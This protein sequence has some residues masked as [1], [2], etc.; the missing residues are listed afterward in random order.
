MKWKS[1]VFLS[2]NDENFD[3]LGQSAIIKCE[4][5]ILQEKSVRV[6]TQSAESFQLYFLSFLFTNNGACIQTCFKT[7]KENTFSRRE[8]K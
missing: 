4:E 7:R 3:R 2:Q 5:S 8:Q 6:E 1:K